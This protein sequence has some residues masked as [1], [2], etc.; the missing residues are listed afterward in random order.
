MTSRLL[1]QLPR[2]SG[3][4]FSHPHAVAAFCEFIFPPTN[5]TR[6]AAY[7]GFSQ[8]CVTL[9]GIITYAAV[10]ANISARRAFVIKPTLKANA[11]V[12]AAIMPSLAA[13][14]VMK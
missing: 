12:K 3:H 1:L 10:A 2:N 13:S 6:T 14:L 11:A 4:D 8:H 9:K 5:T 7:L